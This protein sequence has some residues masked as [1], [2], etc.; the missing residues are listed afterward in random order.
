MCRDQGGQYS[1]MV[2]TCVTELAW[3]PMVVDVLN[4]IHR[5]VFFQLGD[6]MAKWLWTRA[7][8][9]KAKS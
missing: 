1:R 5:L 4:G 8:V 3:E 7:K 2:F 9:N 6:S